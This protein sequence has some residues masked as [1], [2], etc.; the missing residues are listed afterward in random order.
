MYYI[1][2]PMFMLDILSIDNAN[3]ST[4]NVNTATETFVMTETHSFL[5]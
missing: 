4:P 1:T 5:G 2:P 3:C